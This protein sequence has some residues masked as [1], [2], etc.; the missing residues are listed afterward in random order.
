MFFTSKDMSEYS[1]K[2]W[3]VV[4]SFI[5]VSIVQTIV[6]I[7]AIFISQWLLFTLC[8]IIAVVTGIMV[9]KIYEWKFFNK[10]IGKINHKSINK[11]LWIDILDY[12]LGTTIKV[13]LK[14]KDI[15]YIGELVEHEENG[16]ESWLV[17]KNYLSCNPITEEIF[18]NSITDNRI[19]RVAINLRDI[20]RIELFYE[21]DTEIFD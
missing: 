14:E 1:I 13:F 17:L 12:D 9:A 20:N 5:I 18:Y 2:I 7:F 8:I 6:A 19:T 4:I 3:S 21:D 15:L 11:S 16:N 10:L